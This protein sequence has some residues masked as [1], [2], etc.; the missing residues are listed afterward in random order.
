VADRHRVQCVQR[1][2][3][4]HPDERIAR[5]GGTNSVG[6][7]WR[8]TQEEAVA[9]IE[10]RRWD[11]YVE[12]ESGG[13]SDVV[14]ARTSTGSKYIKTTADGEEPTSLLTLPDCT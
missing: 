9:A 13:A 11:F 1:A 2:N 5:I 10:G 14:V 7:N 3:G 6:V 4:T 12:H 8:L